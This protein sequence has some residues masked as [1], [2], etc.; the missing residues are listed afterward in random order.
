MVT[1]LRIGLGRRVRDRRWWDRG[2]EGRVNLSGLRTHDAAVHQPPMLLLLMVQPVVPTVAVTVA[3][4]G[5][6]RFLRAVLVMVEVGRN[7]AEVRVCAANG[8]GPRLRPAPAARDRR[9]LGRHGHLQV[10]GP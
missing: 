6:V 4:S 10:G 5:K 7:G 8:A 1:F 3:V 9:S 2:L